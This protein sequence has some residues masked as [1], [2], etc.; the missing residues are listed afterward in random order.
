MRTVVAV[1]LA[2]MI[3]TYAHAQ[4]QRDSQTPP[5]EEPLARF[6]AK[7]KRIEIIGKR[8]GEAV[9]IGTQPELNWLVG[10]E[11]LSVEKAAKL[12]D[13]KGE[14]VLRI[15]SPALFFRQ[16]SEQ[17]VGKRYSFKVFGELKDGV[18]RYDHAEVKEEK[19]LPKEELQPTTRA[20]C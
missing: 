5:P 7:V 12:F 20:G 9:P 4:Q 14:V 1:A 6:T 11:I 18:P 8:P 16:S 13:E 10:I 2:L 3:A 17:V 19:S 15:H